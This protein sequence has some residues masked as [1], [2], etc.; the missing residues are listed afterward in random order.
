MDELW[1]DCDDCGT[2][3]LGR[4]PSLQGITCP[5]TGCGSKKVEFTGTPDKYRCKKCDHD[6]V[7]RRPYVP[8][9][10]KPPVDQKQIFEANAARLGLDPAWFGRTFT[11]RGE[12]FEVAGLSLR[13]PKMPVLLANRSRASDMRSTVIFLQQQLGA[14]GAPPAARSREDVAAE[15]LARRGGEMGLKPEW[16]GRI[17]T[18][19][20]R[21]VKFLGVKPR[22]RT[23]PVQFQVVDTS[24]YRKCSVEYF[25]SAV[26]TMEPIPTA[27]PAAAAATEAEAE[28]SAVIEAE[29]AP[30]EPAP[31]EPDQTESISPA[32]T[33]TQP[34]RSAPVQGLLF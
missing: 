1:W 30:A 8:R 9:P 18:L 29:P 32:A 26:D 17:F 5:R 21:R 24:E 7:F 16:V 3:F 25:L 6:F 15:T 33:Q 12:E 11:Y 2:E 13:S 31:P 19:N 20:G 14:S 28:R 10:P 34:V 23:M 27:Q 4:G 22:A